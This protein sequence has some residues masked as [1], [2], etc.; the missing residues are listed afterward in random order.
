[1]NPKSIAY[2]FVLLFLLGACSP[3]KYDGPYKGRIID[4]ATG[5]P[6]EGVVVL[7]VW[8]T[9]I[10][11]AGGTLHGFY[12]AMETVTDKNGD[13]EIKGLGLKIMSSVDPMD[14][15]IFKAGYEYVGMYQWASFKIDQSLAEKVKWEESRVIV[16]LK[17]LT[18]EER[19]KSSTFPSMPYLKAPLEKVKL[20]LKEV[21]KEATERGL[22]PIDIWQG[23]KI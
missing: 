15:L 17:R 9:S 12:D 18:V 16:P 21:N 19:K 3:V 11:G 8:Y 7:G 23:E 1:M 4:A 22:H 14:V 20:M 13:F 2:V 5:Q 6:V 10:P